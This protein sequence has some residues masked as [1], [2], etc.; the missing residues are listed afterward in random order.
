MEGTVYAEPGTPDCRWPTLSSDK[1]IGAW[2]QFQRAVRGCLAEPCDA[3]VVFQ[4]DCLVAANCREW[5]EA[6]PP[7]PANV[8]VVSLYTAEGAVRAYKPGPGWFLLP[9][10]GKVASTHGAVAIMMLRGIA[11]RLAAAFPSPRDRCKTDFHL[12]KWCRRKGLR[13]AAH[14]PSLVRHVGVV[15]A[16]KRSKKGR[17]REAPGLSRW[18]REAGWVADCRKIEETS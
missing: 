12:E 7:W 18:R 14:N 13:I 8:G 6:L 16:V 1:S 17:P 2:P 11:E 9:N 3:L 10:D 5:I 4:D 15:S